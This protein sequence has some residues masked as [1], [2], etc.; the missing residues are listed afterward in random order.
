MLT[1]R[2]NFNDPIFDTF[3]KMFDDSLTR[4]SKSNDVGDNYSFYNVSSF[5][6]AN[7]NLVTTIPIPGVKPEDVTVTRDDKFIYIEYKLLNRSSNQE[8]KY[9]KSYKFTAAKDY[10]ISTLN[11]NV[12]NGLLELKLKP[13]TKVNEN[14]RIEVK[15]NQR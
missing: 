8:Q 11:A 12:E 4:N 14:Q 1:V 10:D 15:V 7:N 9:S 13:K 5:V 6:D 3:F 2:R